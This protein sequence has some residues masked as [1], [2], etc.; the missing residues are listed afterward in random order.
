MRCTKLRS[1]GISIAIG[2]AV[3]STSVQSLAKSAPPEVVS[4][5]AAPK[6]VSTAEMSLLFWRVFRAELWSND[7][8]FDWAKPFALSL[9][10]DME[11]SADELTDKTITEIDRLTDWS[12]PALASLRDKISPC[13]ATVTDG[14]RFTAVGVSPDKV[15][16]FLNSREQCQL[17]TP[18]L[19]RA[20]FQIWLSDDSR[21]PT[22]SRRL[23]GVGN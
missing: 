20:F 23:R 19:R 3:L 10:Y 17:E 16:M 6:L 9:T 8:V 22:E 2:L 15:T 11:F 4:A 13:M 1:I 14:D 18:D 5:F 7:G 21:F 12:T